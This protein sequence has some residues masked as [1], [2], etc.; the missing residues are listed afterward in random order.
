MTKANNKKIAELQ[1]QVNKEVKNAVEKLNEV[2]V[3]KAKMISEN[4]QIK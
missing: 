3:I 1:N 4:Q 2:K